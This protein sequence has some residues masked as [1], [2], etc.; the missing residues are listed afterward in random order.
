[1]DGAKVPRLLQCGHTVCH[2]CLMR[3]QPSMLDQQ[4]LL[5][6]FDRQPTEIR[7]NGV[8]TLKKNFALIELLERLEQSSSEKS[9]RLERERLQSTQLC[10]EDEAHTAVLYCTVCSSHLCEA[11]DIITHSSKTLSKHRRVPLS[12]KPREKPKCPIHS[13]HIAEFTCIQEGCHNALMCYL[14]KDYGRHSIHKVARHLLDNIFH[15][16]Y[17]CFTIT[18]TSDVFVASPGGDRS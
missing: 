18:L 5:C 11:C 10:D 7:E 2:T 8:Y 17:F 1:M 9:L 12:E 6:P 15:S 3:L 13:T 14:C 4:L 16:K